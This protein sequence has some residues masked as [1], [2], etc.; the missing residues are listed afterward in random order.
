MIEK[1]FLD[2]Y[3]KSLENFNYRPL[4]YYNLLTDIY[5][6]E[7]LDW[8]PTTIRLTLERDFNIDIPDE[9]I[10]C[11]AALI[12]VKKSTLPF[13]DVNVFIHVVIA[14][15]NPP[16]DFTI[17][18]E[19]SPPRIA[20]AINVMKHLRPE[21]QFSNEIQTYIAFVCWTDGL[22]YL[23]EPLKMCQDELDVI[24]KIKKTYDEEAYQYMDH[25]WELIKDLP[26]EQAEKVVI[27]LNVND[28]KYRVQ[29]Y[30]LLNIKEISGEI[31]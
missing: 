6:E 29:L 22:F 12:A 25:L 27:N 20:K 26:L 30:K 16:A 21:Q 24:L 9:I 1:K 19:T 8:D 15:T 5:K 4:Y 28:N 23:I 3:T 11:I 17:L 2:L 13:V 14:L 31:V 7:W 18:Q 10:D